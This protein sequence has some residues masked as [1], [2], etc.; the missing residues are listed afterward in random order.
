MIK[1]LLSEEGDIVEWL[2]GAV[3]IGLGSIPVILGIAKAIL[4]VTAQE[5]SRI[6]DVIW[7]N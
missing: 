4:D 6:R 5:D 7:A 1:F 3:I 2:V